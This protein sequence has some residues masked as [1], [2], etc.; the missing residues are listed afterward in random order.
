MDIVLDEHFV[1]RVSISNRRRQL[2]ELESGSLCQLANALQEP[3]R[4][5]LA[6][7]V[8]TELDALADSLLDEDLD[9]RAGLAVLR[10]N[11]DGEEGAL[12]RGEG[13][14]NICVG[15]AEC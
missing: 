10:R 3:G 8:N 4:D 1:C 15:S 13:Q 7:F 12:G 2:T 9:G 14:A 5:L 11:G 6:L